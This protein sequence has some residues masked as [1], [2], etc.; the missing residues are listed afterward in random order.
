MP[1]ADAITTGDVLFILTVVA[2]FFGAWWRIVAAVAAAKVEAGIA[3]AAAK[4]EAAT[5]NAAASA[6]ASLTRQELAEHK[7]H[8]AE[9]YITKQGMRETRD[10]IMSGVNDIKKSMSSISERM[11]RLTDSR[12]QQQPRTRSPP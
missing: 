5:Q 4:H 8:V 1:D 9:T 7:L 2:A 11:D 3:V 6:L 12:D 10:E